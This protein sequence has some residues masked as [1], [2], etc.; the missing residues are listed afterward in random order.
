MAL[1]ST[2]PASGLPAYVLGMGLSGDPYTA[3]TNVMVFSPAGGAV[4]DVR[5]DGGTADFGAGY[6]RRRQVAV[7]PVDLK[8]GQ[9]RTIY[10]RLL[11]EPVPT[12]SVTADAPGLWV[13]PG[14]NP[15]QLQVASTQNC[16]S[17]R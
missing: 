12:H 1:G 11:S 2:A 9:T 16:T 14:V 6:E 8:P 10:V 7:V 13:T 17:V 15:W 3:R 5:L 4:L